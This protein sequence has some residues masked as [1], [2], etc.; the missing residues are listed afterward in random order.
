MF[1]TDFKNSEFQ[2][3]ETPDLSLLALQ[4]R[5]STKELELLYKRYEQRSQ[6]GEWKIFIKI[7]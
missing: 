3:I 7:A 5:F 1:Q 2:Y 6:I 4:E